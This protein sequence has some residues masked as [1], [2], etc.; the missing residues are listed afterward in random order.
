MNRIQQSPT[1]PVSYHTA[2][3]AKLSAGKFET[4]L[5]DSPVSV[6]SPL[7]YERN[8][9]YPLIIWLHGPHDDERQLRQIMPLVSLRNYVAVSARGTVD[10][11]AID[12]ATADANDAELPKVGYGWSQTPDHLLLAETR[13]FA[14]L[15]AAHRKFNIAPARV[16]LAGFACGGTMALRMALDHPEVFAGAASCAG[17]FPEGNRPLARIDEVRKLKLL[18]ATGR[19]GINYP[20]DLVCQHLRL[21]HTAGMSVSLRQ[22]PCGDDLTTTMLSDMDRWIMEQI[23]KPVE[24]AQAAEQSSRRR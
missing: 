6:F 16:F 3:P 10:F 13:V 14:A 9:A 4:E 11:S 23:T 19:D 12:T 8:Y 20:P 5:A 18:L 7:H 22:Y 2:K 24:A 1:K 21:F 17:V 15:K